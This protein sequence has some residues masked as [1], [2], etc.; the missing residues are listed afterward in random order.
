[1]TEVV[2]ER[3]ENR[4]RGHIPRECAVAFGV[5]NDSD[6][7][8]EFEFAG[9]DRSLAVANIRVLGLYAAQLA[10]VGELR[11]A[12]TYQKNAEGAGATTCAACAIIPVSGYRADRRKAQ[13]R[14]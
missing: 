14:G 5:K 8:S 6:L 4:K 3:C 1:L 9:G 11:P 10:P 2:T 7:F 13:R 12:F